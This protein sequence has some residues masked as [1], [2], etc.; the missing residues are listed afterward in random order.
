MG[1]LAAKT[2]S[3]EAVNEFVRATRMGIIDTVENCIKNGV[4]INAVESSYLFNN[5]GA[6]T[7][8]RGASCL[9][10]TAI[11]EMLISHGAIVN[12]ASEV[13]SLCFNLSALTPKRI[14]GWP[15]CSA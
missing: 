15:Y 8:L 14:A 13:G 7:A 9:G 12:L 6:Q 11:V 10:R 4:D 3:Q 1:N 5:K 2:S